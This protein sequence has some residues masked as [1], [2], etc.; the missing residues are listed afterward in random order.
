[1]IDGFNRANGAEQAPRPADW[2]D[3]DAMM[4]RHNEFLQRRGLA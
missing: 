2:Q 3:Y 4:A 1:M